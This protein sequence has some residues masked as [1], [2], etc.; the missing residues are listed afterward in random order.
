MRTNATLTRLLSI[1]LAGALLLTMATGTVFAAENTGLDPEIYDLASLE[2]GI[3]DQDTGMQLS[4]DYE[5]NVLLIKFYPQSMFPGKEQQYRTAVEQV[6]RWGFD[7]IEGID[8]YV[9][10]ID[11]LEKNPNAVLNRFK[12]NRFIDFVE[13]NYIGDL[14]LVPNDTNYASRGSSFAKVINAEAG[15]DIITASNVLIAIVDSGYSAISDLPGVNGYSVVSKNNNVADTYGH[16]TQVAGTLAATGNN[17][18]RN[19]GVI[20]HATNVLPVKITDSSSVSVANVATAITYAADRDAKV[21][22]LSLSFAADSATLKSAIDYAFKKGCVIVAATGN[23]GKA[24]VSYPSAYANVLGVGG[25]TSITNRATS[26]NYGNG[27][28]VMANWSWYS[29][30]TSGGNMISGGTSIATP[31]VAG[32][33]ALVWE[34]APN[35]TNTQVMDLIRQ[36]TNKDAGNWDNQMGYGVID[37]GKT[38]AAAAK[39]GGAPKVEHTIPPV[40]RLK[41]AEKMTL[42]EGALYEEPG[43]TATDAVD[44]DVSHLVTVSGKVATAYAG[45]YTLTYAVKNKAGIEGKTTR[46]VTVLPKPDTTPPTLALKGKA[47]ITLTEGDVYTEPGYTAV[48]DADGDITARVAVSGVVTASAAGSYTLTYTVADTAG[49]KAAAARVVVVQPKPAVVEPAPAPA[50]SPDPAPNVEPTPEPEPVAEPEPEPEPVVVVNPRPP[51]ITV[52]GSDPIILHYGIHDYFE[53]GATAYDEIDGDISTQVVIS[54][55]VPG[56]SLSAGDTIRDIEPGSYQVTYAVTNSAGLSAEVSRQVRMLP[57]EE[58]YGPRTPYNFN[59][60]G[61]SGASFSHRITA[62]ADGIMTLTVGSLNKTTVTISVAGDSGYNEFDETFDGA[63][64]RD[65]WVSEGNYTVTMQIDSTNGN[66]K[67]DYSLLTPETIMLVFA[68]TAVPLNT[69]LEQLI[70]DLLAE[71]QTFATILAMENNIDTK[72][73]I[74]VAMVRSNRTMQDM[75]DFGFTEDELARISAVVDFAQILTIQENAFTK[76]FIY[77]VMMQKG[78]TLA[79]MQ[80]VGFTVKEIQ[81]AELIAELEIVLEIED[82]DAILGRPNLDEPR[83]ELAI[84]MEANGYTVDDMKLIGLT[85]NE[86]MR[87]AII[88]DEDVPLGALSLPNQQ[89]PLGALS[90]PNQQT[91]LGTFPGGSSAAVIANCV[92]VNLHSNHGLRYPVVTALSAGTE[93]FILDEKYDWYQV[94]DGVTEGWV[95]SGYVSKN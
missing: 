77:D 82:L 1:V 9:V 12:N 4:Q 63:G 6:T 51:M 31:Q 89:V 40:I 71:G 45:E 76:K 69:H 79:E 23:D 44:G 13:P 78:Y 62:D 32:L 19:T 25:A 7:Y 47:E 74:F 17:G 73:D 50:P 16:G 65:F 68:E 60:Q 48:D 11:E 43:Y 66:T 84:R 20:W 59:D 27:L 35:L 53:Q 41:G 3:H 67:I 5:P 28:D 39:I 57:Q 26:S 18:D 55:T 21:I 49:N 93:V 36:N 56:H 64:K 91:P 46:T 83:Q 90:L 95:Y 54:S 72:M 61:K 29:T 8:T 15:W 92:M 94:S 10:Y 58:K 24:S 38:L 37:M 30:N 88:A 87:F 14:D 86:L 81:K 75:L 22:N 2:A 42:T 52:N 33:A 85:E 70:R 80:N 34:L